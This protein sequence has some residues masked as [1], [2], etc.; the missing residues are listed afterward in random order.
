M[1]KTDFSNE[2]L[3]FSGEVKEALHTGKPVVAL[4]S[5]VIAHGLP[6]PENVA[7]ARKIEAAVRAE[8]AIPA[9]I[10]IENG[11]FLIGMSD[12]DI[13]R[14]GS[15]KGIP[16]ASSRD[17]PVILAQGGMGATTVA[18]SLVAA[19]LAGIPFFA[20]AGIG[21]VH[22]GAERSMDISA[23]LIQFTRSRV[24]V[25]CAGAKSILDLGLTLEYLETQCVPIISYQS[26]DFPAFYCRSSGF[27]SPHRLDDATVIARSVEMHWK[28]GNQSSVLI[29]H[30]IHEDEAID[31]DEVESIIRDAAL[32]AEHEGIRGP[33]A[34]PYL[35][36]AVAKATQGRTV[37]ANMSVLISTAALAGKLARAHTDY[38]RQQNQ[39]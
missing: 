38:L 34:T 21:G 20:S 31:K 24:A 11:R 23:D 30:P 19:D 3:R 32:Q 35:M 2:L 17:I 28:L 33:G 37:K 22:R 14:F 15:T 4:E 29:T 7:T 10:G 6:Y 25:V 9:T 27:H 16:K 5:T 13:E 36:R 26:D 18:S 39:A 1:S 8:G 12:A